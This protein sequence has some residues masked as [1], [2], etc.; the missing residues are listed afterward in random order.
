MPQCHLLKAVGLRRPAVTATCIALVLSLSV[1]IA[2]R[3]LSGPTSGPEVGSVPADIDLPVVFGPTPRFRL[4]EHRGTPVVVEV[5]ASW[6]EHCRTTTPVLAAA[7]L[8]ERVSSVR[9]VAVSVDDTIR[10]AAAAVFEWKIPFAVAWDDGSVSD[11]WNI[12][13]LP[14]LVVIDP[15]GT[16]RHV[17]NGKP[18]AEQLEDWLADV[19]AAQLGLADPRAGLSD[20]PS[21]RRNGADD[22]TGGT[23]IGAG[24][25]AYWPKRERPPGWHLVWVSGA[26]RP[27]GDTGV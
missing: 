4:A 22:A 3:V 1:V 10:E 5:F 17:G 7:A 24:S 2:H 23:R 12:S 27:A 15:G 6:C 9:F 16:I 8:A 25:D 20:L 21:T 19:G 26:H 14:T 18:N 13:L 11:E